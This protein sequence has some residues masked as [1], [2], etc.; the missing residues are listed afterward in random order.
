M[1]YKELSGKRNIVRHL[2]CAALLLTAAFDCYGQ[3]ELSSGIDLSYP[4]LLNTNNTKLSYGQITFGLRFGIAYKPEDIQFFPLFTT[5]FGR[6]RLPL[7]Q[8]GQDVAAL[9]FN[10]IN[11]MINENYVVHA[12][13]GNQVYIYGGI[14]FTHLANRG[15]TIAGPGGETMKESIDSTA[16]IT[17]YFPAMNIGF[18]YVYGEATGKDLYLSMGINFQYILLENGQNTYNITVNDPK[19]GITHYKTDL[20]GNVLQPG[21]YIAAHYLLHPKK[22]SKMYL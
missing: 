19:T 11:V 18:D 5:A 22:K 3:I 1:N 20:T 4:Q 9:N 10:Y 6:T 2:L 16:N 8:F 15:L 7:K 21:F 14:G 17:T 13:S 12:A